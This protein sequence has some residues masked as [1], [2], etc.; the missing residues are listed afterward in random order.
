MEKPLHHFDKRIIRRSIVKGIISDEEAS[1]HLTA[2]PDR[3]D[4]LMSPEEVAG[5]DESSA[6]PTPGEVDPAAGDA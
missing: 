6:P 1:S 2:L 4:N 3:S 5:L